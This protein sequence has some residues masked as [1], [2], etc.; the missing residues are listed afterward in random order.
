MDKKIKARYIKPSLT[1]VPLSPSETAF[2]Y[3]EKWHDYCTRRNS[4]RASS[5][6]LPEIAINEQKK[7]QM[8]EQA[9][10]L[11]L[12]GVNPEIPQIAH[13]PA[14]KEARLGCGCYIYMRR[15]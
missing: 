3:N 4:S 1:G 5:S 11:R 12:A 8:S 6:G 15:L 13:V 10:Q 7:I 14:R 2:Y 9:K